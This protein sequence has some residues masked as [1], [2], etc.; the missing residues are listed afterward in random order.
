MKQ[1]IFIYGLAR[2]GTSVLWQSLRKDDRFLCFDEPFAPDLHMRVR[3]GPPLIEEFHREYM[4]HS[5]VVLDDWNPIL[6]TEQSIPRLMHHQ[7]SYLRR[8][9]FKGDNICA[10]LIGCHAKIGH[11]KSVFWDSLHVL[12]VRDPRGFITS[13]A[14]PQGP[15]LL[16]D[17]GMFFGNF[18][19]DQDLWEYSLLA[20]LYGIEPDL[21]VPMLAK[22]W[23]VA[24]SNALDARPDVVVVH[25][26]FCKDPRGT[27]RRV[28]S[29]IGKSL[30]D[31]KYENVKEPRLGY[32]PQDVG[33]DEARR[34]HAKILDRVKT[35]F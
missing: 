1:H 19:M 22:L 29:H 18:V 14:L 17:P 10:K 11:I 31:F 9:T 34:L 32:E 26:D 5:D 2:T 24:M 35:E 6:I 3:T 25:E 4:S 13:H 33:W 23:Y 30:P 15:L 20:R 21:A 12:V 16:S 8:L 28:Y 27:M 7:I